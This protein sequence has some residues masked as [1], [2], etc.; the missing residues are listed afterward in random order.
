[1]EDLKEGL[2]EYKI[3]GEFLADLR[4]EFGGEDKELVKIAEL[5]KL[6]QGEKTMKKFV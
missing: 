1:M 6:E 5:K 4:K 2:L 3:V